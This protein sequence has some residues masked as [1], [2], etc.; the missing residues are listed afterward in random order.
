MLKCV[1]GCTLYV[2]VCE[3]VYVEMCVWVYVECVSGWV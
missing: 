3:W 2:E 1:C